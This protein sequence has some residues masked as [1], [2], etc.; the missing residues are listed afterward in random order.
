MSILNKISICHEWIRLSDFVDLISNHEINKSQSLH[1]AIYLDLQLTF[2]HQQGPIL[3][4]GYPN[5]L[6]DAR[7]KLGLPPFT[8]PS[9][10]FELKMFTKLYECTVIHS[11]TPV[12]VIFGALLALSL[13]TDES[14]LES[15]FVKYNVT[16][17][18]FI[19]GTKQSIK[20]LERYYRLSSKKKAWFRRYYPQ[21]GFVNLICS[22]PLNVFLAI[23]LVLAGIG[24]FEL[25]HFAQQLKRD[26]VVIKPVTTPTALALEGKK[27]V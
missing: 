17:A 11:S 13:E 12:N 16:N 5:E 24:S 25:T 26:G 20:R 4:F 2:S 22:L 21:R 18:V 7:A 8:L 14:H 10:S 6:D 3:T 27:N 1:D 15:I 19:V 23:V 9:Q